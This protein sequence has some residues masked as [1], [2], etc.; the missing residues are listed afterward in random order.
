MCNNY[1]AQLQGVQDELKE[2]RAK[3]RS[4][5]RESNAEKQTINSQKNYI[6]E[7]EEKLKDAASDTDEQVSKSCII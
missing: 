7:L 1:E 6:T 2:E 3:L 5:E 4:C